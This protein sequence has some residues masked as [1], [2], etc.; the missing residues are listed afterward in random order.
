MVN[1]IP[2]SSSMATAQ[3]S[4]SILRDRMADAFSPAPFNQFGYGLGVGGPSGTV[5]R[6]KTPANPRLCSLQCQQNQL[7]LHVPLLGGLWRL[8]GF[9]ILSNLSY[10]HTRQC[11]KMATSSGFLN[12]PRLL[13][14]RR[15]R[16]LLAPEHVVAPGLI[17]PSIH[18]E[19]GV[20][21]SAPWPFNAQSRRTPCSKMHISKRRPKNSTGPY[22]ALHRV[23]NSICRTAVS[24]M[25]LRA[26]GRRYVG[27]V[28]CFSSSQAENLHSPL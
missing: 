16:H 23:E 24:P 11:Q 28:V 3:N 19:V 18:W 15:I 17:L 1:A 20:F 2:A 4:L 25:A 9:T 5:S 14:W 26:D 8:Y 21:F 12:I 7:K 6:P 10:L 27:A 22:M 13:I